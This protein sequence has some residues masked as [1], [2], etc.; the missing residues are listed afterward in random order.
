MN[1]DLDLNLL[2]ILVL[3]DKHRQLKPVA[4]AMGKSEASISKYLARL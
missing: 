1:K 2:K 4:K 3:L